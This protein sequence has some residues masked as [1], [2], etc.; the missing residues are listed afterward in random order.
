MNKQSTQNTQNA[1]NSTCGSRSRSIVN[2]NRIRVPP[3]VKN[4]L[5]TSGSYITHVNLYLHPSSPN[6]STLY[7]P[8]D[9]STQTTQSTEKKIKGNGKPKC[10]NK[11]CHYYDPTCDEYYYCC[12]PSCSCFDPYY[13]DPYPYYDPYYIDP[14]FY[15]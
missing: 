4:T 12:N 3:N 2:K 11:E 15:D 8:I 9:P 10:S 14:Y 1:T 7:S 6:N 5:C 13:F